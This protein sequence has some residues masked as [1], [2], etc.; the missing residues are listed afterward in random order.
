[1]Y[2]TVSDTL[3]ESDFPA[4]RVALSLL[5]CRF[6]LRLGSGALDDT[7]RHVHTREWG[8]LVKV[9]EFTMSPGC[10]YKIITCLNRLW[11]QNR[12]AYQ[13]RPSLILTDE[14]GGPVSSY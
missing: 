11:I 4:F 3:L 7:H 6:G 14:R 12:F 8:G 13:N 9:L 1:M 10:R 5:L 2:T